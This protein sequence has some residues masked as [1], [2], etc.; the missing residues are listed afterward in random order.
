MSA[1]GVP[2]VSKA[3][4]DAAI[5]TVY[6]TVGAP[7]A[8]PGVAVSGTT[9]SAKVDNQTL[10]VGAA[11]LFVKSVGT[12]QLLPASVTA[13]KVATI[14]A[15]QVTGKLVDAQLDTV[16]ASKVVG[17]LSAS[18][19]PAVGTSVLADGSVTDAKVA[20]VSGSKLVAG[21]VG[22]SV[23]ADSAVTD[24]KVASV[25]GSKLVAGT[26]GT[27]ALI[28]LA[29]TDAKVASV[30]GSKLVA[31]TIGT[32]ALADAAVSNA[33]LATG[34][35][36][37]KLAAG[38]VGT[39]V[40]ADAAVTNAKL[41]TGI[42]GAKLNV[43]SIGTVQLAAGSVTD[44]KVTDVSA[45]KLTGTLDPARI[46]DGA[47]TNAK[48]ASGID[49]AKLAGTIDLAR[50]PDVS[51]KVM[52]VSA[53][54]VTGTLPQ[55]TLGLGAAFAFANTTDSS[56]SST[57]A[58]TIA[59]GLGVG[60][61]LT[62]PNVLVRN[63][64]SA[65]L[66]F[67]SAANTLTYVD[68]KQAGVLRSNLACTAAGNIEIASATTGGVSLVAGG[69]N[70]VV[71]SATLGTEKLRVNGTGRF[72]GQ[73]TLDLAPVAGTDAANKAYVDSQS[74]TTRYV[75]QAEH[76]STNGVTTG[77]KIIGGTA[78]T[79][80]ATFA[81][82][83]TAGAFTSVINGCV[84]PPVSGY[85]LVHA[86]GY[87][88]NGALPGSHTVNF[89]LYNMTDMI[90]VSLVTGCRAEGNVQFLQFSSIEYLDVAKSYSFIWI[91]SVAVANDCQVIIQSH[92][93]ML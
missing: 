49:S 55:S 47:L 73:L 50:L 71:G 26:V 35:D 29:V 62:V 61:Q 78:S 84:K 42:D 10:G 31:G 53:A 69:G 33:K 57:G 75:A 32:G 64:T 30:S 76:R 70:V 15:G 38:T 37:S 5:S 44:A 13:D 82:Q 63:A 27:A 90:A 21:T 65:N 91:P 52:A 51:A 24:A 28:D 92:W 66:V 88:A 16:S 36:G 1:T 25:S 68:F 83:S 19:L 67:D 11:G 7:V 77:G 8:G 45:V 80:P 93:T 14:T 18:N 12:A 72:T 85:Y 48:L 2:D 6:A 81:F 9:V 59:G 87:Y 23:L 74:G 60:K 34:I 86:K 20:S 46:A 3:Y 39:S 54:S 89:A 43:G 79:G 58:V 40:L 56:T 22:T 41:A 17:V 4:V